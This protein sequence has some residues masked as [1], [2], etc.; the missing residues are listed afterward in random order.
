MRKNKTKKLPA[1][2]GAVSALTAC[3]TAFTTIKAKQN[4]KHMYILAETG[5]NEISKVYNLTPINTGDFKE[6]KIYGVMK[7]HVQQYDV[8][9]FGN[10]S[11]MT[12]NMGIMQM[13]S[14]VLTPFQK[15]A[16]MLSMDFMY[17]LG[18]RKTYTEYYNLT[19]DASTPKY[20]AFLRSLSMLKEKYS[21]LED[22][23]MKPAWYDDLLTISLHKKANSKEDDKIKELFCDSVRQYISASKN[24][25]LLTDDE[26]A[27][28]LE[29]T[30]KYT[31]NLIT[32]GGI[33]TDVFKKV[34][35]KAR[36]KEF[37]DKAFFGT[38]R[39]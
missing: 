36:T 34:L 24:L 10:L 15:D 3:S 33:S 39:A 5:L 32:K 12:M 18:N 9:N 2:F 26:K 6:I 13:I 29:I 38:K 4:V 11:V 31:D 25:E 28:K 16:P 1:I 27:E 19:S 22:I 37:F 21:S 35:G 7:F 20:T 30:Q 23:K 14:F 17:I 8:E